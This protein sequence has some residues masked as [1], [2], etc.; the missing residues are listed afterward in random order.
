MEALLKDGSEDALVGIFKRFTIVSSKSIEDE[1]EKGW[2]YRKLAGLGASV[3]PAAKRF[4]LESENIAW[5]LRIVEDVAN[6]TQEWDILNT[7]LAEFPPGYTRHPNKKKEILTHVADIDDPRVPDILIGYL[8][9]S[10]EGIRFF[11]VEQLIDI[12]DARSHDP[13]IARLS[14]EQEDSL[15][16]RTRILDGLASLGVDVSA[17]TNAIAKV[18]GHEHAIT[19]GKVVRR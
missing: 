13:L 4:C 18:I 3:L 17:H 16:L 10:D 6:E 2:A 11:V 5:A 9:D 19:G 14:H 8:D 15:R 1:E 7:L 12:G